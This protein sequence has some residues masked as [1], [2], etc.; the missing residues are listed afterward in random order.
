MVVKYPTIPFS[1]IAFYLLFVL[2]IGPAWMK[3]REPFTLKKTLIAYN[4]LQSAANVYIAYEMFN[5]ISEHWEDRCNTKNSP[6]LQLMLRKAMKTIWKIYLLKFADLLDTVFFVL[7]KKQNQIT[8]LHVFHHSG[9]CLFGSWGLRNIEFCSGF[10]IAVGFFINTIV[11]VIMY[12]YYGLAACGPSVQKY[13]WWKKYLTL[14]Q[15]M[16]IFFIAAYMGVGFLTGCEVFGTAIRGFSSGRPR[17][18]TPAD[19][20]YIVLQ[21]RRNRRQT[22]E[23]IARHTTQATGRPI[24]RFTG[25]RRLH[26]G[27]LFARRPVR[28]VPLTPAHR[29]R[30]SLWCREHRNWRNIEWVKYSLQM[31]ADSV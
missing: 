27:V 31:R 28:C 3:N 8:F 7:R 30:R 15:I 18:T 13:L 11:H 22:A 10:Y 4:F 6:K 14:I 21:A 2:W 23:E 16:Q 26:G 5:S 24:S 12:F 9:L 25:A 1:I 17:G 20:R 29:K 19:D